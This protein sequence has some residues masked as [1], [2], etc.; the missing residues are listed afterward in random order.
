MFKL[1]VSV[2]ASRWFQCKGKGL[3]LGS[4]F[5]DDEP[6]TPSRMVGHI[7]ST[8]ILQ[9]SYLALLLFLFLLLLCSFAAAAAAALESLSKTP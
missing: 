5:N 8:T 4:G 9:Y 7:I 2:Q 1:V 6:L 3:D